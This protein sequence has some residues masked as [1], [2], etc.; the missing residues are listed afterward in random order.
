MRSLTPASEFDVIGLAIDSECASNVRMMVLSSLIVADIKMRRGQSA[1]V[2]IRSTNGKMGVMM[3][4]FRL[5][6]QWQ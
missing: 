3:K 1:K 5:M 4:A 2:G 6:R